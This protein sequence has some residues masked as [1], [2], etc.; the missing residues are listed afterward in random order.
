MTEN[1][2]H[3][4]TRS[5]RNVY[6]RKL[7]SPIIYLLLLL[8]LWIY[9]PIASI[10]FPH[11]IHEQELLGDL[12]KNDTQ[13]VTTQLTNLKFTGYTQTMLGYTTGYYYY[14]IRDGKCT[15]VLLSPRTSEEGL[16][17]IDSADIHAKILKGD[18]TFEQLLTH[19]STDLKW[20]PT[21]ITTK[22][23]TY[24][25]SEPGYRWIQS[26]FLIACFAISGLYAFLSILFCIAC[27]IFPFLSPPIQQLKIFGRPAM[28]LAKAE[29]ELAT[30]PQ[31]AT[32]DMFITEHYFIA[33]AAS[34]ISIVPIQEIVWIYKHSTLHKLFWYHFSISYTLHITANKHLYI[35]CPKN[36][37]SDIDG[38]MDYLAEANHNILVGFSEANRLKVQEIQGKPLQ[39]E[40]LIS[41]LKKRI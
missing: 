17:T 20:T 41:F 37:K 30:L 28:I 22:V 14:T 32:E 39:F 25:L 1:F 31:L 18:S 16:P 38:I 12:Y 9:F 3:Y 11:E 35:R 19:L 2:E 23:S 7:F 24:Y 21:A 6:K 36:L 4:I 15:I 13:Y 29:E 33:I 26:I 8:A 27:Y 40:K 10:L 34:G 5:I